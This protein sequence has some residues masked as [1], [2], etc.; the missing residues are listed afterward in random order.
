MPVPFVIF[1]Q[2]RCGSTWLCS[3]LDSHPDVTCRQEDFSIQGR[4]EEGRRTERART[5]STFSGAVV[6]PT[7][8]QALSHLDEIFDR[9][10][11]ASGFKFKFLNQFDRFPEVLDRLYKLRAELRVILLE[12]DNY[13]RQVLSLAHV[14]RLKDERLEM[15]GSNLKVA[16]SRA[17]MQVDVQQ[18]RRKVVN[19]RELTYML[20]EFSRQFEHVMS[21]EYS[22]LADAKTGELAR[23]LRFIEVDD[24]VSLESPYVKASPAAIEQMVGN[25]DELAAS[26]AETPFARFLDGPSRAA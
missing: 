6:G 18:V 26:L 15:T 8:E 25:Y 2:G 21:V 12:R 24:S 19:V 9:G 4:R 10:P 3:L 23:L 11:V 13:L 20:R 7:A 16:A 17:P 5:I 22:R 1:F 14:D